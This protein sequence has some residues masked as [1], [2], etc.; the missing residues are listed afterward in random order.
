MTQMICSKCYHLGKPAKKKRG[1]NKVEFFMWMSFPLGLPYTFWRMLTKYPVCSQCD[2]P[3]LIVADSTVG[4]R[5]LAK[6]LESMAPVLAQAYR[7]E[8]EESG[9]YKS[10]ASVTGAASSPPQAAQPMHLEYQSVVAQSQAMPAQPV[11]PK[12]KPASDEW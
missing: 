5:L 8:L 2:S 10:E 3:M 4:R 9:F 1:S 12:A 11:L 7:E 6:N